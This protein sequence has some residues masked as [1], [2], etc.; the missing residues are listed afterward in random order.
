MTMPNEGLRESDSL[1]PS[2]FDGV[3]RQVR[4]LVSFEEYAKKK[5]PK[6]KVYK[7]VKFVPYSGKLAGGWSTMGWKAVAVYKKPE[8]D[9]MTKQPK[10]KS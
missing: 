10:D 3:R 7:G 4:E 1:I 6:G 8:R 5:C 9:L 2:V